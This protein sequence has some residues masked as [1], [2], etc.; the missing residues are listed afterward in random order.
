MKPRH[1]AEPPSTKS[2]P[3]Q[4]SKARH[5]MARGAA[6]G[7]FLAGFGALNA[8]SV[9]TPNPHGLRGLYGYF[10]AT[11]GDGVLL[12]AAAYTL[13]RAVQITSR[14]R[15]RWWQLIAG[16][17]IGAGASAALMWSWLTDPHPKLDWTLPE[18]GTFNAAGWYHAV[19]LTLTATFFCSLI[20][21]LAGNLYAAPWLAERAAR[22][23]AVF[24][25]ALGAFAM[26]VF[27]DNAAPNAAPSS[28][29]IVAFTGIAVASSA[30]ALWF[31]RNT[32]K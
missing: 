2:C 18:P 25:S 4:C 22:W 1:P 13:V 31:L 27:A 26:L 9:V 11:I 6:A 21:A 15:F 5:W 30:T 20:A 7:V 23:M 17:I 19:F 28:V 29:A 32:T 10:S 12:P 8:Y 3:E 24:C 14:R 16:A